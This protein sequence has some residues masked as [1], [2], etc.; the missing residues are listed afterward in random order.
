MKSTDLREDARSE[1]VGKEMHKF[2]H[3]QLHSGSKKGPTVTDRK[4]AIAIALSS[5]RKKGLEEEQLDELKKSTL[6]SYIKKASHDVATK[7]AAV[8]R[9]AD[10]AN[11]A[12]D[13]MM[14]G[15]YKNWQQGKKDD[16][17][18]DKMFKKSWKRRKGIEKAVNKL[19]EGS[20]EPFEGGKKAT[21]PVTKSRIK[22]IA[23]NA[24]K[25]A[26]KEILSKKKD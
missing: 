10:R 17:F 6:K 23:R 2:K 26:K 4:Q 16:E 14:K 11:K 8:G 15:D 25:A 5:A 1:F 24:A 7:S 13:E 9:Y 20:G 22:K 21:R 12:R 18:T 19:E 3:G